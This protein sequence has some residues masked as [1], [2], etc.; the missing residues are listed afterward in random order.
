[1]RFMLLLLGLVVVLLCCAPAN[2]QELTLTKDCEDGFLR[3]MHMAQTGQLGGDVTNANIGVTGNQV[4]VELVR[5]QGPNAVLLLA[6]RQSA[7]AASRYFEI[8]L[9]EGADASDVTRV[10]KA[11]DQVFWEDPF[12]ILGHEESLATGPL[13]SVTEAWG[14]GGWRGVRRVLEGRM[15]VLASLEYTVGLI[16][17]MALGV[18]ASLLLLWLSPPPP[19][20]GRG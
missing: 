13:P 11:L 6:P 1:M 8:A 3:F 4:R 17:V 5:V 16:A 2:A 12:Q 15:M 14:Y 20:E 18:L 10:G 7:Q 19:R 9:G